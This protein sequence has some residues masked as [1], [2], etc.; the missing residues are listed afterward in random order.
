MPAVLFP[1]GLGCK[2]SIQVFGSCSPASFIFEVVIYR[3]LLSILK[4]EEV[5]PLRPL[6]RILLHLH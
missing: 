2:V 1:A 5:F 4:S 3:T 6:I